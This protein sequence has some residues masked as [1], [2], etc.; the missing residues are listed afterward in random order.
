V[1]A[2][3][4]VRATAHLRDGDGTVWIDVRMIISRG[5]KNMGPEKS[6]SNAK[7]HEQYGVIAL[8]PR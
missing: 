5:K 6:L 2:C 7:Y 1:T 3:S 8:V 4:L